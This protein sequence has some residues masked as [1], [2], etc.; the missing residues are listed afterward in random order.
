MPVPA[1]VVFDLGKVLLD[2]DYA[3]AAPRIAA[4]GRMSRSEVED[5]LNHSPLLVRYETGQIT[6]RVFYE[7]VRQTTGFRGTM[8]ELGEFFADIFTPI[9]PMLRLHARLRRQRVPLYI[10]SNSN[11]LAIGH[12]RRQFPFFN[13]FDGYVLSYRVGAMKPDARIY[14]ALERLSG[15]HGDEILYLDDR[16][17]NVAAGVARGWQ[18]I[19][20]ESPEKS[21][22]VI[23]QLKLPA[24]A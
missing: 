18:A 8:E 2:F 5:Y 6:T 22:A 20:H 4:R 23:E 24:R 21:C 15:R 11:D 12:I 17:E 16:A 9:V 14:E 13:E 7:V 19:L 1:I 10:L 3:I